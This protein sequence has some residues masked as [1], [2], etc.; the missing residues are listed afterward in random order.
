LITNAWIYFW[1]LLF[2]CCWYYAILTSIALWY[3][4]RSDSVM[5]PA[6]WR[7]SSCSIASTILM[8]G[9]HIREWFS[10]I[11][12]W[13]QS[14]LCCSFHLV[15]PWCQMICIWDQDS[16]QQGLRAGDLTLTSLATNKLPAFRTAGALSLLYYQ[17][18]GFMGFCSKFFPPQ[19][20]F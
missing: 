8:S 3:V 10:V 1:A 15:H 12:G 19:S 20:C 16:P 17:P 6:L 4:L 13:D 7:V 9:Y 2:F 5:P 11:C 14:G 18:A